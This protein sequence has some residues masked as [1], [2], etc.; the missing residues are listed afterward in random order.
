MPVVKKFAIHC[1]NMTNAP[2]RKQLS[3]QHVS[4]SEANR[5]APGLCPAGILA[6]SVCV[7]RDPTG[8][9]VLDRPWDPQGKPLQEQ[10][11]G[12]AGGHLPWPCRHL[13]EVEKRKAGV[14]SVWLFSSV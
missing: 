13:G 1:T 4:L 6:K 7:P 2:Q 11:W 8:S 12:D 10:I 14:Q 3:Q 5:W 9:S